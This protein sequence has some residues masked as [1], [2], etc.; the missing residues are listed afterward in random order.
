MNNHLSSYLI[1]LNTNQTTTNEQSPLILSDLTEH[2][3]DHNKWTITSHLIWSHWTQIRPQVI[4]HL[5]WFDLCSVRSDKMRGDCSFVVVWFVFSEIRKD[6]RWLF[7]CCGLICVQWDQI[8]WEVIVHM[9][10]SDLCSVR[11]EKMRGDCS[12]VVVWFVLNNHLTSYL[13]SLNTNQTTTN[14][15]SPLILSDLTEHK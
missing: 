6:E 12:F 8:R 3:S 15:Q 1:S 7:I 11:S 10:W 2:K 13:I 4:V 14:E 5:L 9:L